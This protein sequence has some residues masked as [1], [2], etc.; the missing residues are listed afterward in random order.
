MSAT[1]RGGERK[2]SDRYM[3]PQALADTI[4]ARLLSDR[5]I[6]DRWM[7]VLEP[8]AGHGAFVRA[9]RRALPG[10]HITANDIVNDVSRWYEAGADAARVGGFL[11]IG[12]SC[13][14]I[15]GNPPFIEAE[16]HTRH[17]L[18][19]LNP[20]GVLVFLLRVGFLESME[21]AEFWQ[22]HP[23][24]CLYVLSERPSFT[25]GGTDASAYG[26]FVWQATEAEPVPE[27]K[28]MSWRQP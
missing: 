4:V 13:D 2:K 28:V 6:S 21:R 12:G 24:H 14:L 8:S 23:V 10:A 7:R 19:L 15:I 27:L 5:W 11:G 17:A 1:G 3:T 20:D 18:S 25:G 26:L 22:Q 16:A 9:V